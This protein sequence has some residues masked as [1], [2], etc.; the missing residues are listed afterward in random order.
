MNTTFTTLVRRFLARGILFLAVTTAFADSSTTL[1]CFF[2]GSMLT[3]DPN[4][5]QV[6]GPSDL[7]GFSGVKAAS[8]VSF[9]LAGSATDFTDLH[10]TQSVIARAPIGTPYY[11]PSPIAISSASLT[12]VTLMTAGPDRA[13]F[14]QVLYTPIV[15]VTSD[16]INGNYSVS[17]PGAPTVGCNLTGITSA[18]A[19]QQ[20]VQNFQ[21]HLFSFDLGTQ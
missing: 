9:S 6:L 5:C 14:I 18:D 8:Q 2:P 3:A 1:F 4:S 11:G 16:G 13:G 19:C 7:S 10:F 12:D 17:L 21:N 15:T 20:Y